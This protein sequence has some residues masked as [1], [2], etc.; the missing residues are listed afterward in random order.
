[1]TQKHIYFHYNDKIQTFEIFW[2]RQISR[3]QTATTFHNTNEQRI[4]YIPIAKMFSFIYKQY[5]ILYFNISV[6]LLVNLSLYLY[7]NKW[8]FVIDFILKN[9]NF[10]FFFF[11]AIISN[12][13][14]IHCNRIQ[15]KINRKRKLKKHRMVLATVKL[16]P[17]LRW[18]SEACS[19]SILLRIEKQKLKK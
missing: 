8:Q 4:F 7:Y 12:Q 19:R 11:K 6:I 3:W 17:R 16:I 18:S 9:E 2:L 5:K 14:N 1:M 15:M 13:N 10:L